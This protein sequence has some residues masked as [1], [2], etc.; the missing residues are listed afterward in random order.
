VLTGRSL[1]LESVRFARQITGAQSLQFT[2][3]LEIKNVSSDL[4][5]E[6]V[7]DDA[8]PDFVLGGNVIT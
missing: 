1:R 5:G 8:P 4:A 3:F 6:P 2:G 7:G